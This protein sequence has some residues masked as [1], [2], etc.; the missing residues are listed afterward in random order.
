MA[1][2]GEGEESAKSRT[3]GFAS[4]AGVGI[5]PKKIPPCRT[6]GLC[7]IELFEDQS[8]V[9]AGLRGARHCSLPPDLAASSAWTRS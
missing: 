5:E 2:A 7:Q 3:L 9:E 8:T 6:R 4:P 1:R